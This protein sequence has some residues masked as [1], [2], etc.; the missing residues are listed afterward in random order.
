MKPASP[1]PDLS[2]NA[3][4]GTVTGPDFVGTDHCPCGPYR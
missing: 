1:E 2:G 3:N 4:H